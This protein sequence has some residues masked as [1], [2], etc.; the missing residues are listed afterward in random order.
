MKKILLFIFKIS[1][2]LTLVLLQIS[3]ISGFNSF[4]GRL[5]LF[6]S[7]LI[8]LLVLYEG[9][10]EIFW[11]TALFGLILGFY[12]FYPF[13]IVP[14]LLV[15]IV[16]LTD[17][18]LKNFFIARSWQALL[19]LSLAATLFYNIPLMVYKYFFD[20]Y[21]FNV[22]NILFSSFF[23]IIFWQI[24]F[25]LLGGAVFFAVFKKIKN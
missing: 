8:P 21:Y 9:K 17:F 20:Q 5:Q 22:T 23:V 2:L 4:I 19:I 11:W 14:I 13:L 3:F 7:L 1:V 15:L 6:L 25:N 10:T 18:F 12:S 24:L 16:I